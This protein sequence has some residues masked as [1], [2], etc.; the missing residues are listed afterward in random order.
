MTNEQRQ[1]AIAHKKAEMRG[2]L[3]SASYQNAIKLTIWVPKVTETFPQGAA[4]TLGARLLQI[5]SQNGIA[6]YGGNPSFVLAAE[7]TPFEQGITATV[8]TKSYIRYKVTDILPG[9]RE[10]SS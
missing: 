6:G 5:T 1:A 7:V 8:P 10:S 4:E 9:T 3:D 2:M